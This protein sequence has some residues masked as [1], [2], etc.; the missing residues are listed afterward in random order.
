MKSQERANRPGPELLSAGSADERL[1]PILAVFAE[2]VPVIASVLPG[3]SE[4]IVHDFVRMPNSIIALAGDIT[5]RQV[6]GPATNYLLSKVASGNFDDELGYETKLPDGRHLRSS[7]KVIRSA[8]GRPVGALCINVDLSMWQ[9]ARTIIDGLIGLGDPSSQ[10][11]ATPPREDFARNVE[12]LAEDLISEALGEAGMP[13][14]DMKKRHKLTVV[15]V[16]EERGF[17]LIKDAVETIAERLGVTKFTIYN[18]LNE[19]ASTS[20]KDGQG[21]A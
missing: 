20:S 10:S 8:T 16:L 3:N 2:L 17:F 18:Y 9:V 21:E 7:T 4:V 12:E 19:I 6:G 15:S 5:G 11:A 1:D 14:E 13:V